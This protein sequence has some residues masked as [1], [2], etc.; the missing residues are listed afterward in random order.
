MKCPEKNAFFLESI[1]RSGGVESSCDFAWWLF[2]KDHFV[3][4][5]VLTFSYT[6][7]D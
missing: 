5:I 2:Y 7:I 6:N 4:G 3:H 1:E